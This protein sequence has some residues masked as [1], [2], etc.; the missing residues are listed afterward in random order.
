MISTLLSQFGKLRS[1]LETK[2]KRKGRGS[3]KA[4]E[5]RWK[6]KKLYLE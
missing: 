6:I 4:V 5:I 1:M 2:K 3:P